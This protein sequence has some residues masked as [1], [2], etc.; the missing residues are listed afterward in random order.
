MQLTKLHGGTADTFGLHQYDV[1]D[2]VGC[3]IDVA[4]QAISKDVAL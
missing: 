2:T 1:G 3:F 4:E